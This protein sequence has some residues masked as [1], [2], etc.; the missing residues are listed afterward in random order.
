MARHKPCSPA[1]PHAHCLTRQPT[2]VVEAAQQGML[3]MRSAACAGPLAPSER[4]TVSM[5]PAGAPQRSLEEGVGGVHQQDQQ[6]SRDG[7]QGAPAQGGGA[8]GRAGEWWLGQGVAAPGA[9]AAGG[10]PSREAPWM[11]CN[12]ENLTSS[13]GGPAAAGGTHRSVPMNVVTP[14]ARSRRTKV[15]RAQIHHT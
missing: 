9:A 12:P 6:H 10:R 1:A 2:D 4:I 15:S 14:S 11:C 8:E 7:N 3:Q 5:R 13:S